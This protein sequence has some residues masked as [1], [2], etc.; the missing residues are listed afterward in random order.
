MKYRV[1]TEDIKIIGRFSTRPDAAIAVAKNKNERD[2][3]LYIHEIKDGITVLENLKYNEEFNYL[4]YV[5]REEF[6]EEFCI[7]ETFK[8]GDVEVICQIL[9]DKEYS[10]TSKMIY[11]NVRME[12]SDSCLRIKLIGEYYKLKDEFSGTNI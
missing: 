7:R 8:T 11:E 4:D 1:L 10:L 9:M 6:V 12:L 2:K 5:V 3:V